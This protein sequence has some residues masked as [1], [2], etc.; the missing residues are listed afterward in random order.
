[1]AVVFGDSTAYP[2][3]IHAA[4]PPSSDLILSVPAFMSSLAAC[5]AEASF[6][7]VQ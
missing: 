7:Q 2:A 3:L 4:S 5:A 1:M 6:G